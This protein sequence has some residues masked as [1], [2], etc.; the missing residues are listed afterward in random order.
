MERIEA[1]VLIPGR[2]DAI[3]NGCVIFDGPVIRYAGPSEGAPKTLP[4]TKTHHVPAVMP[5]M[6]D[7]HT[8]LVGLR[9]WTMEEQVYTSD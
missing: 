1:D 8:H 5:G 3:N 2:G 6:W 4:G 9:A 7:T